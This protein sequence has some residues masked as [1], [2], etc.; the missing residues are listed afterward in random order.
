M[1]TASCGKDGGSIEAMGATGE[2][3]SIFCC[4]G[5]SFFLQPTATASNAKNERGLAGKSLV[6]FRTSRARRGAG[7]SLKTLTI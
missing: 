3:G 2:H 4:G 5:S 7:T 6:I 1:V